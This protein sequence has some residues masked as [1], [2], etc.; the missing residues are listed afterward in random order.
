MRR[1]IKRAALGWPLP[2]SGSSVPVIIFSEVLNA[3]DVDH[4]PFPCDP[5]D[6]RDCYN[7]TGASTSWID[8]GISK[9]IF[10]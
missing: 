6:L 10:M 7:G 4:L 1:A 3:E 9:G 2:P 8:R 5:V